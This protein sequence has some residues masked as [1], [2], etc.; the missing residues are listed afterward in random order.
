MFIIPYH[1][2]IAH[3]LELKSTLLTNSSRWHIVHLE[4]PFFPLVHTEFVHAGI[5]QCNCHNISETKITKEPGLN[6]LVQIYTGHTSMY[7]L[8]LSGN[9]EITQACHHWLLYM[10]VIL[11]CILLVIR[12]NNFRIIL[13]DLEALCIF[14]TW[15]C[16][17]IL[18]LLE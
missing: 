6:K 7:R 1:I 9:N 18:K 16:L 3:D 11:T 17:G 10:V 4:F 14:N 13:D 5:N 12:K 2:N 8:L 15:N